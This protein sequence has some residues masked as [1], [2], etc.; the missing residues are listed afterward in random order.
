[1]SN[2]VRQA[3]SLEFLYSWSLY[4]FNL[5]QFVAPYL[6]SERGVIGGNP[7]EYGL[8][9][10]AIASVL[11][12]WLLIRRKDLGAWRSLAMGAFTLGALALVLALGKYGYLY[13]IQVHLPL[14]GL[15]RCPSRYILLLHFAMA[16]AAA[17]AFVDIADLAQRPDQLAWRK[18]WPLALLPVVSVLLAGFSIWSRTRPDSAISIVARLAPHVAATSYVIIGPILV[19][20]ATVIVIAASRGVRYALPGIILFAAADQAVYGM[21]YVW[22]PQP[23][24]ISSF[25]NAQ[26]MPPEASPY[27]V[28]SENNALTMKG[29]RLSDGDMIT[30]APRRQLDYLRRASLQV[31]GADWIEIAPGISPQFDVLLSQG[32]HW[33]HVPGPMAR[34]RLVTNVLV[35]SVPNDD[36]DTIEIES[37]AL[38][39]EALQLGGGQTGKASLTSD[40]PGEIKVVTAATS[41]QLL[42]LS[43]SYHEG[44]HAKVDSEARPVLRVNGDFMG[45]VVEAGE[46][47]VEFSFQPQSFRLGRW[48][49]A[50][51]LGLMLL[52]L[53]VSLSLHARQGKQGSKHL[54]A[55]IAVER[56]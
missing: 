51:G 39:S 25:V 45:C 43:E 26:P 31:A 8:Y 12:L 29:V 4:P 46:H 50:L 15:F 23:T 14:V 7:H 42:V 2:S 30:L 24:D 48:L 6:L 18:L 40:R 5:I 34:A 27:R 11:L 20:C 13:R 35:S 53:L 44:W 33:L 21:T 49:S 1:M 19:T 38:V 52:S 9:N 16:I 10:G 41:R 22:H 28:Q 3:P 36:I 47:E 37:T 17:I 54:D 32:K 55:L 56:N